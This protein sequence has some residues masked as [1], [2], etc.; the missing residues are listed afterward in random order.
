M[1]IVREKVE[2]LG[3]TIAVETRPG[4]GTTFTIRLPK[5]GVP[6]EE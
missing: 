5:D 6:E 1:A 3:G 2:R 4:E